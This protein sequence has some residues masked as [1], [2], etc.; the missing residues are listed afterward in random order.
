[1]EESGAGVEVLAYHRDHIHEP[2]HI[3]KSALS[4]NHQHISV[5]NRLTVSRFRNLMST[6]AGQKFLNENLHRTAVLASHIPT[7]TAQQKM[8]AS[9]SGISSGMAAN[10]PGPASRQA[11]PASPTDALLLQSQKPSAPSTYPLYV[12]LRAVVT[13]WEGANKDDFLVLGQSASLEAWR[14]QDADEPARGSVRGGASPVATAGATAGK[15]PA[16]E[17]A[18]ELSPSLVGGVLEHM[19]REVLFEDRFTEILDQALTQDTPYFLQYEDSLPPGDPDS[20]LEQL[21]AGDLGA[22]GALDSMD[23]ELKALLANRSDGETD[24]TSNLLMDL[25]QPVKASTA[26]TDTAANPALRTAGAV[27]AEALTDTPQQYWEDAEAN[28]GEVDLETF[29]NAAGEVL[30]RMLLDMMDDVVAGR[31]NWMRPILRV[32]PRR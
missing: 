5:A 20:H 32:R 18:P 9:I 1:V 4:S 8:Q 25:E 7:M 2:M 23:P 17:L 28:Y 6:A 16:S 26:S 3:G 29:K 12:R 22:G 24:W 15:S 21:F 27:D 31:L 19:I 14:G 11:G 10:S 30:D 13:D